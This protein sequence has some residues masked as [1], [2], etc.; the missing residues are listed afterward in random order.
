MLNIAL[1]KAFP[2]IHIN[3]H[4]LKPLSLVLDLFKTWGPLS[5]CVYCIVSVRVL[6]TQYINIY[7]VYV[8]MYP[9]FNIV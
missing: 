5:C 7:Y 6:H 2:Q 1:A 9:H 4:S 8:I 3:S